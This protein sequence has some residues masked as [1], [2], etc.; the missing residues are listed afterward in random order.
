M[1]DLNAL[2]KLAG[3]TKSPAVDFDTKKN[4]AEKKNKIMK[5]YKIHPGSPE[6]FRLWFAKP[7]ITGELPHDRWN[8]ED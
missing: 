4:D 3:I 6:W 1:D 7:H 5:K 2:R 8:D